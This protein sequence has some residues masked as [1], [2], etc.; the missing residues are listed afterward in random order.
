MG[1]E[2]LHGHEKASSSVRTLVGEVR[3]IDTTAGTLTIVLA[4]GRYRER[5][6]KGPTQ[7]LF[8][9]QD[10]QALVKV[11]DLVEFRSVPGAP[12]ARLVSVSAHAHPKSVAV[13]SKRDR[14][15]AGDLDTRAT[16]PAATSGDE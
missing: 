11:G 14:P 6:G 10:Q 2:P 9:T 8:A 4:Q 3:H 7:T 13:D 16:D 1:K 5:A 15:S 12:Y